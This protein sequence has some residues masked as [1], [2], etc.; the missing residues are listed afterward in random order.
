MIGQSD[1][2]GA[3]VQFFVGVTRVVKVMALPSGGMN[4]LVSDL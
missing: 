1:V 3:D 2:S 4:V